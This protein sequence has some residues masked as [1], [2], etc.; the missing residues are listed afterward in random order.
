M[1]CKRLD[2]QSPQA[3]VSLLHF[4]LCSSWPVKLTG[5]AKKKIHI[6][7]CKEHKIYLL[8]TIQKL[9]EFRFAQQRL[10]VTLREGGHI[11]LFCYTKKVLV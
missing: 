1:L 6:F 11:N 7:I 9:E 10:A 2:F 5:P 4:T 8:Y 3:E